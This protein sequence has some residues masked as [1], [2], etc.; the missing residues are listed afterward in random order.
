MSYPVTSVRSSE[1]IRGFSPPDWDEGRAQ[2]WKTAPLIAGDGRPPDPQDPGPRRRS[3][4]SPRF[5]E[6]TAVDAWTE[7][8][9]ASA[10]RSGV[11]AAMRAA[12]GD[13]PGPGG[14]LSVYLG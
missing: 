12:G 3:R 13:G 8:D 11:L 4:V 5:Y 2:Q 6:A 14:A 1:S 7:D 10:A 9:C